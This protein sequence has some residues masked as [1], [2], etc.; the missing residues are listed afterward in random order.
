[1]KTPALAFV[2]LVIVVI[3]ARLA[4]GPPLPVTVRTPNAGEADTAQARGRLVYAR[5]GCATCHG[6][7]GKGGV[8][9]PNAETGGKIPEITHVAEGYTAEELRRL[10]LKGTPTIGRAN[11][12]GP[13]PPLRMPGW[14]DRM[15][16]REA[17]D[18]AQYLMS[19]EPKG[20]GDKWR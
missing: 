7:E 13:Q 16:D 12:K 9:N 19:L 11:P 6:A 17:A 20:G 8:A 3:G 5:Y 18:L 10:I 2:G 15:S 4:G 1:M 14:R